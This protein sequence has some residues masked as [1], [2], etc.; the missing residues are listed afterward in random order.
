M[1]KADALGTD[2]KELV[3]LVVG[4]AK[5]ETLDPLKRLGRTIAFGVLGAVLTGLGGV[6]L[7]LATLR[8]LQTETDV[9]AGRLSFVPY[10]VVTV[11]LVLAAG[12]SWKTLGPG[13]GEHTGEGMG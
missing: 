7:G 10:V 8:A 12:V 5:Q 4:Y 11:L 6:F 3:D 2:A 9:F 13:G 1:T